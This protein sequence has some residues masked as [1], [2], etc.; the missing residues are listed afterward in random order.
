MRRDVSTRR[1]LNFVAAFGVSCG[2]GCATPNVTMPDWRS[3]AEI[4]EGRAFRHVVVRNHGPAARELLHV[5]I[6]GDGRPGFLYP[7]RDP[8]S[9]TLLMLHL[10][11][12]DPAPSIYLG[13]PCY[14]GL[15][16]DRQ[17]NSHYW[18]D[19]RFSGGSAR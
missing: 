2:V 18:T 11:E 9:R 16:N 7:S 12:L 8:T 13:R 6:E 15:A 19:R 4:V 5:Y 10:M 1:C 3:R 14:L 17:C